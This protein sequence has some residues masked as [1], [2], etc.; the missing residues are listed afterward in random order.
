M[1]TFIL[2]IL[3]V[4]AYFVGINT[5]GMEMSTMTAG[6]AAVVFIFIPLMLI[7]FAVIG[8]RVKYSESSGIKKCLGELK[9]KDFFPTHMIRK[10]DTAI[11]ADG[12]GLRICFVRFPIEHPE[13]YQVNICSPKQILS[14]EIIT[15]GSETTVAKNSS[16]IGRALVGGLLFGGVGAVIGGVTSRTEKTSIL[17]NL[18]LRVLV[19]DSVSQSYRIN[20]FNDAKGAKSTSQIAQSAIM[21]IE[22]WQTI[23]ELI[24]MGETVPKVDTLEQLQDHIDIIRAK[25]KK[26]DDANRNDVRAP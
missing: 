15:N 8:F 16:V 22:L 4:V 2:I 24:M 3:A 13:N 25:A 21:E 18:E 14:S 1:K 19:D 10:G 26:V 5:L 9:T 23:M 7:P 6:W 20:F 12:I 17:N 11:M